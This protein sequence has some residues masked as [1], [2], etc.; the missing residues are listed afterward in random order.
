ME[1]SSKK[2]E[3]DLKVGEHGEDVVYNILRK[4]Q[5]VKYIMDVSKA[6]YFQDRDVDYIVQMYD[7][8]VVLVEVKRDL[9]IHRTENIAYEEMSNS[10]IGC[11]A[12]SHAD[13]VYIVG[14]D[15]TYSIRLKEARSVIKE[16]CPNTIKGGDNATLRLVKIK[17]LI[18]RGVACE[19][20]C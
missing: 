6:K 5:K 20:N 18:E 16:L 2:F 11:L 15:K 19:V 3:R 13:I 14:N 9:Q 8:D 1:L 10:H 12:R 7:G 4:S 17:D